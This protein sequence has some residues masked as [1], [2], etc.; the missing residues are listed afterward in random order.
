M[1][2][3]EQLTSLSP[4]REAL[5]RAMVAER[6]AA[7]QPANEAERV[8]CEEWS[9][10]FGRPVHPLDDFFA[11]GGDSIVALKLSAR[12][13]ARGW[14][15]RG[16]QLFAHPVVRALAGQLQP[17]KPAL[18]A[19]QAADQAFKVPLTPMQQGMLY[20]VQTASRPE[21]CVSQFSCTLPSDLQLPEFRRG[22]Q[23]LT[24]SRAALRARVDYDEDGRPVMQ[25]DPDVAHAVEV[26]DWTRWE[27]AEAASGLRALAEAERLR[28]FDVETAPLSRLVLVKRP[29]GLWS[30]VWTHHHL[31]LDGWSQL[32]LLR[33]FFRLYADPAL[34][35]VDDGDAVR[36][37]AAGQPARL[38][39]A[40][41]GYWQARLDG[42]ARCSFGPD[43]PGPAP[44]DIASATLAA[45]VTSKLDAA[46]MGAGVTTAAVLELAWG[47]WIASVFERDDVVFGLVV[48]NRPP[49]SNGV[50][51]L[52]WM[53]VNTLPVRKRHTRGE[54]VQQAL[55]RHPKETAERIERHGDP[56]PEV[57]RRWPGGGFGSVLV[58]ENFH[59][60]MAASL[61][62]IA[63]G[64]PPADVA[65]SVREHHPVVAVVSGG[66]DGLQLEVKIDRAWR[67]PL[68]AREWLDGFL[69]ALC[70][71]I[72]DRELFLWDA[73]QTLKASGNQ[74]LEGA[75]HG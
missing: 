60:G 30:C 21:V 73:V 26:Q 10:I 74:P 58:I 17:A 46:A 66:G 34:E 36:S 56:L 55:L 32:A 5:L 27:E 22:W 45:S 53:C 11:L 18:A 2:L 49:A 41:V 59:A 65:F 61:A 6:D 37:Y 29:D 52:A 14:A 3:G 13:H 64:L 8:L 15:L 48:A 9:A 31:L 23:R 40:A 57:L 4:Q 1:S 68:G 42:S 38:E 62:S 63:P 47:L 19:G 25:V 75:A 72:D 67:V 12:L 28:G 71:C 39:P 70:R 44:V 69:L 43:E 35:L 20:Q 16:S 51:H 7:Q 50:E 54:S 33:D 24:R